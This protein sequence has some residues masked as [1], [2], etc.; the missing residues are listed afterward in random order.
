LPHS[1]IKTWCI[2]HI[3]GECQNGTSSIAQIPSCLYLQVS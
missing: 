3:H 2:N 1:I